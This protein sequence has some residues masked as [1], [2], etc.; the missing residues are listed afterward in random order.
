MSA[1]VAPPG[2]AFF[3]VGPTASGKTDAAHR[4][5]LR[6][7]YEIL[8]ADS[9]LV[10][11]GM[12]IGTAK[13][14]RA[15][16]SEIHYW[17]LDQVEPGDPFSLAQFQLEAARAASGNG[18]RGKGLV[19]VG[20]TGLYVKALLQGLDDGPPADHTLRRQWEE[21]VAKEGIGPLQAE[22]RRLF[23]E[24][25]ASLNES[26]RGNPRRL[27]RAMEWGLSG[28]ASVRC[29]WKQPQALP[30]ITGLRLAPDFLK[31]RLET[32]VLRMYEA[33][34]LEEV[35]GLMERG[36]E[37]AP[38]ACQAI[39]YAEAI[40]CLKGRCSVAAAQAETIRR[41]WQ[42]AR[43]QMIW[44]RRQSTIRWIDVGEAD[45]PETVSDRV[46]DSWRETGP[47]PLCLPVS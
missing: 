3:L 25:A 36:F 46:W 16:Q 22:L 14:D 32:R 43:H 30:A 47:A 28:D 39:G 26:D 40:A 5:A 31:V 18:A 7:G 41:T 19:V 12:D 2:H 20:G 38:T 10:Y 23:P 1:L 15:L 8:S 21:R 29:G 9:M 44:F 27:M 35:R 24:L 13:P 17:G 37:K 6:M 11:R 45:S 33:G 4:L 34:L 42:L